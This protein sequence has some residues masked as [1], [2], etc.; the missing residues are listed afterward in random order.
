[1]H[2]KVKEKAI[3]QTTRNAIIKIIEI[4]NHLPVISL[5]INALNSLSRRHRQVLWT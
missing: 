2:E 4:H 1:M 5:I 3:I